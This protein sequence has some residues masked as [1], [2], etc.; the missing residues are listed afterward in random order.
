[1]HQIGILDDAEPEVVSDQDWEWGLVEHQWD[2][3]QG[4]VINASAEVRANF[5][6]YPLRRCCLRGPKQHEHVSIAEP[7]FD[8]IDD[9]IAWSEVP[10]IEP[11]ADT[12][13]ANVV[14]KRRAV[15]ASA[16][17]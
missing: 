11:R 16:L 7:A 15:S 4:A 14:A 13:L 6:T 10:L 9:G 17:L 3:A 5:S 12:L 8:A 2:D 1:M